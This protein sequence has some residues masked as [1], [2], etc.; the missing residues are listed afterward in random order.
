MVLHWLLL[1]LLTTAPFVS[2]GIVFGI[3]EYDLIQ[4]EVVIV[5]V[6]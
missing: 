1:L 4:P 2:V 5:I 6:R 3:D